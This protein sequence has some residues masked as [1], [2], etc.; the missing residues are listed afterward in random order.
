MRPRIIH[1][2]RER[3]YDD[4]MKHKMTTNN[5]ATENTRLKTRIQLLE[6][7]LLKKERVIDNL[8]T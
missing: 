3:L 5:L 7:D 1:Q 4:V 2:D 8:M 6:G